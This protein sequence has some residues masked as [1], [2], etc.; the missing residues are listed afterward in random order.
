MSRTGRPAHY[1][2]N[3][4]RDGAPEASD[5]IIGGWPIDRLLRMNERFVERMWRAVRRGLEKPP[6][7]VEIPANGHGTVCAHCGRPLICVRKTKRF[8]DSNCRNRWHAQH[9]QTN[10]DGR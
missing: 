7:E 5:D 6:V 8:C 1:D 9:A 10:G 3:R 2:S 4:I